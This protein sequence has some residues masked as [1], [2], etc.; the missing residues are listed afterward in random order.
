MCIC[1]KCGSTDVATDLEGIRC[2]KCGYDSS[3]D[4]DHIV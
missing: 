3:L 1:P 4:H 2:Y